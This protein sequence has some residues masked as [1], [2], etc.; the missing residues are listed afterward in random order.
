MNRMRFILSLVML[1]CVGTSTCQAF[2]NPETGRWLS[3]DPIGEIGSDPVAANRRN[4]HELEVTQIRNELAALPPTA[5]FDDLID[6]LLLATRVN[7]SD[8]LVDHWLDE[9]FNLYALV[10][11]DPIGNVDVLGQLQFYYKCWYPAYRRLLG[12][13]CLEFRCYVFANLNPTEMFW[14]AVNAKRFASC[15]I[16]S[17]GVMNFGCFI[18]NMPVFDKGCASLAGCINRHTKPWSF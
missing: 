16:R 8:G 17:A 18:G 15:A 12:L 2:Y 9:E 13:S 10:L 5:Q 7:T 14:L 6:L 3:R 11:N 4:H 1:V